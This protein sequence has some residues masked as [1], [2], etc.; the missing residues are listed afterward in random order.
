MTIKIARISAT[1]PSLVPLFEAQD[2]EYAPLYPPEVNFTVPIAELDR[3]DLHF[4]ALRENGTIKGF[5]GVLLADGFAELKR[6]YVP[7]E[8]RGHGIA[9][10]IV[11]TLQDH[12]RNN[13]YSKVVLE[14]GEESPG[15][16]R[17]YE[18]LGYV[19]IGPFGE[20]EDNGSSVFMEKAL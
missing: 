14:T 3:R 17:L 20:Y 6:I 13:G 19:R 2:E 12:A 5:G 4:F 18:K 9:V 7:P 1:E 15:A 11:E 16:I 10:M 8:F